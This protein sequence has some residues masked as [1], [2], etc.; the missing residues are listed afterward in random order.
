MSRPTHPGMRRKRRG[1]L[2]VLSTAVAALALVAAGCSDT[3]S[4]SKDS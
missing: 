3:T 2:T 4:S 1:R